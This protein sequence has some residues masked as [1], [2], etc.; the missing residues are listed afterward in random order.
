[1]SHLQKYSKIFLC[2]FE[3]E[4]FK[5][6]DTQKLKKKMIIPLTIVFILL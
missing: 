4:I 6:S 5:K 3:L 2:T 1:M